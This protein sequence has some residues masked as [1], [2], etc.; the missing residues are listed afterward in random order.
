MK[1]NKIL[2]LLFL[3]L[4]S[5]FTYSETNA[6]CSM[7]A[8]VD[9]TVCVGTATLTGDYSGSF[10][11]PRVTI[12][13]Q[14]SGPSATI[15]TPSALVTTVSGLVGGNSYKFRIS[16][17]CQDGSATY[18]EVNVNVSV[19][20]VAAAGTDFTICTGTSVAALNATAL[21]A[22]ET[23]VWTTISGSAGLTI[24]TPTSRTSNLV[25]TTGTSNSGVAVL[26]WTVTTTATG[27]TAYDEVSVTKIAAATAIT[28]GNNATVSGCYNSTATYT[29]AGSYASGGTNGVWS[30]VS[31]PNMPT[32]ANVNLHNSSVSNLIPGVYVF[33]WTVS[34]AC[35]TG[36]ATVQITISAALGSV[37]ASTASIS[38]SPV[39][40]YCTAPSEIV[41]MGSAY[42]T[43]SETVTWTKLTGNAEIVIATP[44][45]RNTSV[46][47]FNGVTTC[48]FRYTIASIAS[49]TCF[50]NSATITVSF[51]AG[52]T[53]SISTAKPF[54]TDCG[55][56]TALINI[57][58]TGSGYTPQWSVISGPVGYTPTAYTNISG[59][60]FTVS[61]LTL[62]GNYLVRV[63]KVVGNCTTLFDE[64]NVIVSKAPTASNAGSD[65]IL[66]CNI[67]SGELI[68]NTPTI[69]T[70]RWTQL[71]GPNTAVIAAPTT[72]RCG[73]SGLT[74]GIYQFRW[75]ISS[76][77]KCPT[78]QDEVW[79]KIASTIPTTANA[80]FDQ[81]ICN[82]TP[83]YLLGNTPLL[84]ETGTWTASPSAGLVFSN[85]NSPTTT[86]T[87]L[88]SSASYTFTWTIVN[89]CGTS[90][91]N[92]A[93]TTSATVGP[94]ASLAGADQCIAS[95][96]TSITMAGNNPSPG[97]GSWTKLTGGSATITDPTLYNTSVTGLADGTYTFEWAITRNACTTT[98]DTVMVTIS[99]ATTTA[100]AGA[101]QLNIC[102]TSATLA[103]NMPTVGTGSWSQLTG[104]G[105]AIITE[106]NSPTT[107]V[108]GLIDGLY[109]FRWTIS[110]NACSSSVD[111]VSIYA[112]TPP[113][114]PLAGNDINV[115]GATSTTMA[116][117][118][119]SVGTGYW[120]LISGPNAPNITN[121]ALPT[122]TLTGLVT[123]E[124]YVLRWNSRNGLCDIQYDEVSITVVP[125]ANAGTDQ[126]ICGTTTAAL[127][128]NANTS[129]TWSFVSPAQ[130]TE[131]INSTSTW[132]S[133]VS[134]LI[135]GTVYTF[136]YSI[137]AVGCST[138]DNVII[139][140]LATPT[141]SVAGPNIE[142]CLTGAET[143]AT[144][145]MAGNAA[146]VGTG[147]WAR[148]APVGGTITTS[149]LN[150]TTITG[151][152]TGIYTY[153]WTISNGSC[154]NVDQMT[155][156]VSK[157]S[158]QSAGN[159]QSVC[160][161]T[162]TMAATAASSGTGT[163][164]QMSGPNSATFA[165]A[166]SNIS[167]V[168]GLIPGDY[169]FRWT[170]TDGVCVGGVSDDMLLTVST[171]PTNPN[172]GT[173]Q[174]VCNVT[175]INLAGNVISIGTG[176]WSRVSGPNV[177][178]ITDVNSQTSS[179]TGM[180]TG[181]YVFRWTSS[182]VC[183]S[184][185][186]DVT[187]INLASPTSSAA[188]ADF[189][190]CLY[191]PLNLAANTPTVGT[192]LWT[193]ISGNTVSFTDA[194][195]PNTSITGALAGS[196][197]FRWSITNGICNVS[198]DDVILTVDQPSTIADAG[199]DQTPSGTSVTMTGNTITGGSGLWTK[200]SGPSSA[201]ITNANSPTTTISDLVGGTYVYRWTSTN[202]TCSSYDEMTITKNSVSCVV[203][204]RMVRSKL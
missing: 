28:A 146:T 78:N 60:S 201:S 96:T 170:I 68:G 141:A 25:L 59:N 94:I 167:T 91:D 189:S 105:G 24:S 132:S 89:S 110:N 191:T 98:R 3:L 6:N 178:T 57:S 15:T 44:N 143:T 9:Q 127:T 111:D 43:N 66:A 164:S 8:G 33:R 79:V 64:I 76:G 173:D 99:A 199:L 104:S 120:S 202:G 174:T 138:N 86:V 32:F 179:V 190:A 157:V 148:V 135:P 53:L 140:V 183:T 101:D 97:T 48:T 95:G 30:V 156:R 73:I 20:P 88:A 18:D 93:V 119:I 169:T 129:G 4:I 19:F 7:N 80:G 195:L 47:G 128:G 12:W 133:V 26:R 65:L 136:K 200:T 203:S 145:T 39:M 113:T 118:T 87:G 27:C 154:S 83:L 14:V 36:S 151:I 131:I 109:S 50:N 193:Q 168:T 177:P 166:V 182:N 160:G 186:D 46:T 75:T 144:V 159:D 162:A 102:G 172:A 77:P 165:S 142:V 67:T 70:G 108:T 11:D 150:T 149:S 71:S 198:T 62:A 85:A 180:I 126:N 49:P 181:T 58:Q 81:A 45:S 175:S 92:V 16:S 123:G 184:L 116:A 153:S 192:G 74:N 107:T 103:A 38:G 72:P 122:T 69:G 54:A 117:N 187:I 37:S 5:R 139:N 196:Y 29:L 176:T 161:T 1:T 100:N 163:W 185:T 41:L 152:P 23:G 61:G 171:A 134:N 90:N 35:V 42:N 158:G 10:P 197:T 125:T 106:P 13:S 34:G 115:C 121:N 114:T 31:G 84:N 194:V 204:N 130:T 52:Q 22:G 51:E 82:S 21:Q 137:S 124:P 155:V 2:L 55:A 147:T 188:G 40:P 56:S 63:K 112:S 17:T